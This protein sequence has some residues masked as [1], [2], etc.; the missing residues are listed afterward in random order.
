MKREADRVRERKEGTN[1]HS[2]F[3][4]NASRTGRRVFEHDRPSRLPA[5][6]CYAPPATRAKLSSP[7]KRAFTVRD[8]E[9]AE[10][11]LSSQFGEC[12]IRFILSG[13]FLPCQGPFLYL[14]R[15]LPTEDFSAP[16]PMIRK[17]LDG[18]YAEEGTDESGAEGIE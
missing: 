8:E 2:N 15:F 12:F 6:A 13:T 11:A 9:G 5:A 4:F 17:S 14:F 10:R 18:E 1:K 16:D 7:S 3:S